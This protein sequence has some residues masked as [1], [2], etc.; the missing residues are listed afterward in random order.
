[1]RQLFLIIFIM[2]TIGFIPKRALFI[3]WSTSIL[4]PNAANPTPCAI[5]SI[6]FFW[7]F[8]QEFLN[9]IGGHALGRSKCPIK[10]GFVRI[11]I[12]IVTIQHIC[13][14]NYHGT[15]RSA[16]RQGNTEHCSAAYFSTW[17][18]KRRC[19]RRPDSAYGRSLHWCWIVTNYLITFSDKIRAVLSAQKNLGFNRGVNKNLVCS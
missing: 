10:L 7:C 5:W 18:V 16:V 6:T 8:Y 3:K 1:M 13:I 11:G 15:L 2:E 19:W 4:K 14:T 9:F 12:T 17:A